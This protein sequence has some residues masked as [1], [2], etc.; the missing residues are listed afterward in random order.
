M[1]A[2]LATSCA[3]HDLFIEAIGRKDEAD[4]VRLVLEHWELSRSNM[5]MFIAPKGLDSEAMQRLRSEPA[6]RRPR[7]ARVLTAVKR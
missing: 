2:S 7:A 3:R 6:A 4:V 1:R 5:E